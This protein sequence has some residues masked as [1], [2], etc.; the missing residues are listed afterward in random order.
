MPH[1]T[2]VSRTS[3]SRTLNQEGAFYSANEP[4][5]GRREDGTGKDTGT[6]RGNRSQGHDHTLP[7]TVALASYAQLEQEFHSL[8]WGYE[9]MVGLYAEITL[10]HYTD[11]GIRNYLTRVE[12]ILPEGAMQDF[13]QM[14]NEIKR[15]G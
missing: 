13:R 4:D 1:E 12:A 2:N 10:Q 8:Q 15:G 9:L 7:G 11:E 14:L 3:V 6:V 5:G